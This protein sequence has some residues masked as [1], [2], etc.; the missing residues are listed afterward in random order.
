MPF[1]GSE[2]QRAR[3]VVP[4][5]NADGMTPALSIENE[6]EHGITAGTEGVVSGVRSWLLK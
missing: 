5:A 1:G 2:T 6:F 4:F 3:A